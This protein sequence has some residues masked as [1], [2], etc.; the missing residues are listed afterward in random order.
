MVLYAVAACRFWSAFRA[1][2]KDNARTQAGLGH[3]VDIREDLF[4]I[5]HRFLDISPICIMGLMVSYCYCGFKGDKPHGF[6]AD[7]EI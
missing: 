2:G 6:L 1:R 4:G 3:I 7:M 5:M